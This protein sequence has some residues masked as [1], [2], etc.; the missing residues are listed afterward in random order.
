[1]IGDAL[2][3]ESGPLISVVVPMFNVSL[4][5]EKCVSSIRASTYRNLEILLIDDGSADDTK[6]KCNK[7]A[8][9][10][11][12][13]RV[14]CKENGGVSSARNI[15]LDHATGDWVTFVDADDWIDAEMI[16]WLYKK[17]IQ[18][19][20][21]LAVCGLFQHFRN[22]I[23]TTESRKAKKNLFDSEDA[24]R[25]VR[26]M[27]GRPVARLFNREK[28]KFIRFDQSLHYGEDWLFFCEA[29]KNSRR[30]Y[31]EP[32]PFYHQ[33][34]DREGNSS[35]LFSKSKTYYDASVKVHALYEGVSREL[36]H[37][38]LVDVVSAASSVSRWALRQ[39]YKD[40]FISY[41]AL[42]V[43]W[44]KKL[45]AVNEVSAAEKAKCAIRLFVPDSVMKVVHRLTT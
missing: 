28:I 7:I 4:Y 18:Y 15:G 19:E 29:I 39:G 23:G 2:S 6:E 31:Y 35:T 41:R 21:D 38:A 43:R 45:I 20:A 3:S 5:L 33:L 34:I 36:G 22:R 8:S 24:L 17:C 42:G 30:V 37:Y 14:I 13:V 11:N 27:Q 32:V 12:R 40:D 16:E 25:N 1:M 9:N 10:D 44:F 26:I